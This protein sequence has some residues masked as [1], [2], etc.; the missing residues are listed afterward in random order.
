MK[1]I[2]ITLAAVLISTAAMSQTEEKVYDVVEQMPTYPGGMNA[3]MKYLSSNIKYPEEAEE[4]GIQGRVICTFVV[5]RDGSISDVKVNK[6]VDPL[7][8]KESIRVVSSMPNWIPGKLNG[9]A[10]RVK[11]TLPITFRLAVPSKT[12]T[13]KINVDGIYY[14][15]SGTEA[16]V[17]SGA[18]KYSGSVTIPASITSGG[19]TYNVTSIGEW[20]FS[21]CKDL[22]SVIIGSSVS[23]IGNSAFQY[24]TGLTS[25]TIGNSVTSI[26]N[27]A[28]YGCSSL[29]S[30]KIPDSVTLIGE[31]AFKGCSSLIEIIIPK[32][33]TSIGFGSFDDCS[34]LTSIVVES[35][36]TKYD[37]RDNCNGIIE[38]ESNILIAK[39]KNTVIPDN[40]YI[41]EKVKSNVQFTIPTIV[42]AD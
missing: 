33:V 37:S 2:L 9:S 15:L 10:V 19:V 27:Q 39:C 20:A 23:S 12:A 24:C 29:K 22:T 21:D 31:I 36:N 32:N 17:T 35:G 42:P 41:L 4:N 8:D 18:H 14:K 13:D 7:L 40:V 5:E 11:Y 25:I 28:F 30:V 1:N 3:L 34:G 26:G 6:S 16:T 38:K